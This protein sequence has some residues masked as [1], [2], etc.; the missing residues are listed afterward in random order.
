MKFKL[1]VT[2][3]ILFFIYSFYVYIYSSSENPPAQPT[4]S[5]LS[6]WKVWQNKN[7]HTCHQL[8]GLGGYMGPDL[9]NIASDP[10]KG[11][12]AYMKAFMMNG[13]G[14]MPNLHL[15]EEEMTSLVSFLRWVDKSGKSRVAKESV[16]WTGTYIF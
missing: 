11:S 16:H 12:D 4:A 3:T 1:W 15:T 8:Y 10:T 13:T 7:C 9:T 6:G 2:L 5:V 14:K